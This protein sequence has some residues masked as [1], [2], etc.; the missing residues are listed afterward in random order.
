VTEYKVY[1]QPPKKREPKCGKGSCAGCELWGNTSSD[2][3]IRG[4]CNWIPRDSG[5]LEWKPY[6]RRRRIP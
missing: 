2:K 3:S 1:G 5:G 4:I 6:D